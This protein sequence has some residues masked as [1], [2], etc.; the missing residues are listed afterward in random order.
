[1]SE[2]LARS[3][4]R[5]IRIWSLIA[6]LAGLFVTAATV[7]EAQRRYHQTRQSA[8]VARR[9]RGF[10][11]QMLEGMVSAIAAIDRHD[12]IRSANTAFFRIFPK[13]SIGVSIHNGI[14]SP[15]GVKLLGSVTASQ[16]DA[17]TYRGR[18]NLAINGG[19]RTFDVYSSP[20]EIDSERGQILTLVDVTEAAK[21]EAGLR[22]T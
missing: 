21:T 17:A 10:S 16:V 11:S 5:S 19:A 7:W 22:P 14:G 1:Q 18:W 12:R 20:L 4:S 15:A 6:M 3:A 9:E 13:A 8:E 2:Q